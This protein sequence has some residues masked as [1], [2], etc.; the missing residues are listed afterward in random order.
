MIDD[1]EM[2]ADSEEKLQ[3]SVDEFGRTCSCIRLNK[4]NTDKSAVVF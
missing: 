2:V 3:K 4:I 1:S